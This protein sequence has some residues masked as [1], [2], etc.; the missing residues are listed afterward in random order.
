MVKINYSELRIDHIVVFNQEQTVFACARENGNGHSPEGANGSGKTRLFLVFGNGNGR[1][2]ARNGRAESWELLHN[3][4]AEI[5]RRHIE[6]AT[7]QG[8]AVY[9]FSGASSI[10]RPIY[11]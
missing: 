3:Q 4:D 10:A 11:V 2:Y 5:I 8:V 6:D 9:Q 7:R 1:V